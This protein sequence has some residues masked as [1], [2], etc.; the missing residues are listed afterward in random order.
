MK[1]MVRDW[2]FVLT[3]LLG[4]AALALP[5]YLWQADLSA[6]AL[7]VRL[8]SSSSLELPSDSKIHDLQIVVNGTKIE[9]PYIYS[10]AL[11]NTGS[12]P[13]PTGA[14]ETPLLIRTLN[15]SRLVTAQITGSDPADIPAKILIDDNQLKIL[16]FLSNPKDRI[17]ITLVS[18]GPLSLR[19]QARIAGVR[20]VG[21]EDMS[22]NKSQPLVAFF[23]AAIAVPCLA[24]YF[25]FLPTSR[26]PRI[27]QL[28][29]AMRLFGTFVLLISGVHFAG[30]VSE[31]LNYT[32]IYS[33]VAMLPIF[34][35]GGVIGLF[36]DRSNRKLLSSQ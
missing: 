9:E 5:A 29:L 26:S 17:A 23:S 28:G 11:I 21:F 4:I 3:S 19:T 2:K 22:Q 32:G 7:T 10:L 27:F 35:I 6:Y 12:K 30:N 31:A 18:S 14:F 20:D 25:V 1:G 33:L 13:I 36:L 16:P 15:D 24:L 34:L 8:V